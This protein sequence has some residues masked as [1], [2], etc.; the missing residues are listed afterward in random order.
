LQSQ[1][2]GEIRLSKNA[3]Q[4]KARK[5]KTALK[6]PGGVVPNGLDGPLELVSKCLGEELLD[7]DLKLV[8]E[9]NRQTRV[10]IVLSQ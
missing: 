6:L 9:D 10:D 8:R 7:G 2:H 5:Q 3:P 1:S 4:S